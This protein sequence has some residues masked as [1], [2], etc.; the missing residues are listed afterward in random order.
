[1][2]LDSFDLTMS[3]YI[4]NLNAFFLFAEYGEGCGVST[5]GDVYSLGILLL[6]MFT[7]RSPTDDAFGDSL[8]LRGFSEAGFPGRILEIADPNLWAHL[9]DTVTRN[10]VRECLLAVIRLA[11]SCSKRQPKDRT[12]V[13]DAATEM[14]AIRDEAYLMMLAG[15]VV[16]RMEGEVVGGAVAPSLT[17]QS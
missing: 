11:L 16:V 1:L 3:I 12:P 10:R 6:E 13:R 17:S 8:D 9:P 15:S 4:Y 7:G 14:R 5:L 2:L